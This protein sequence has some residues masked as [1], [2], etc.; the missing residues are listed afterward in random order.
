MLETREFQKKRAGTENRV[1]SGA[2]HACIAGSQNKRAKIDEVQ[3]RR[4]GTLPWRFVSLLRLAGW[5][6]SLVYSR[7]K[8]P[9]RWHVTRLSIRVQT[10]G[11]L[12]AGEGNRRRR[13]RQQQ[14]L[15]LAWL[16]T[17]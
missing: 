8:F 11:L 2:A 13:R 9:V 16:D 15:V 12:R 6:Y 14:Q 4:A 17:H 7:T 1:R 5:N 10:T 3:Q